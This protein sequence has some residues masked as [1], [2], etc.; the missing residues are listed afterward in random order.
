MRLLCR[1]RRLWTSVY[2]LSSWELK[3]WSMF[4]TKPSS[5][6][7]PIHRSA[8]IPQAPDEYGFYVDAEDHGLKDLN[9]LANYS[10]ALLDPESDKWLEAMNAEMQSMK[11]N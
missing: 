6:T 1:T 8:R 9:E 4:S 7:V 5:D 3:E 11:D 2:E 10:S